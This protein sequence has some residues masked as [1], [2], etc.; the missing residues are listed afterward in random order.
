M[1]VPMNKFLL[2]VLTLS[3]GLLVAC[4]PITME[5]AE[6]QFC[7]DL[8]MFTTTLSAY[9]TLDENSTLD[10]VNQS[11]RLVAEAYEDLTYSATTLKSVQIGALDEAYDVLRNTV[12]DLEGETTV[13]EAA[14][15]IETALVV[16][17]AAAAEIYDTTCR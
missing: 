13:G 12:R 16:V 14:A 17:D 2:V 1:R 3:L 6:G 7:A 10:E 15:G 11:R 4:Q 5:E 8:A 9:R